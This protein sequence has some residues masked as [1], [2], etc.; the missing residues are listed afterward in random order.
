MKGERLHI[1]KLVQDNLEGFEA[2]FSEAS[3]QAMNQKL[4]LM[5]GSASSGISGGWIAAGVALVAALGSILYILNTSSVNQ[6]SSTFSPSN[7]AEKVV[8]LP[9]K[10]T[11][12]DHRVNLSKESYSYSKAHTPEKD[13]EVFMIE[14]E[15]LSSKVAEG[16]QNQSGLPVENLAS[17]P[18]EGTLESIPQRD[19]LEPMMKE[20]PGTSYNATNTKPNKKELT[21]TLTNEKGCVGDEIEYRINHSGEVTVY[22]DGEKVGHQAKG[23]FILTKNGDI[24]RLRVEES[25]IDGTS[26]NTEKTVKVYALPEW[27][28]VINEPSNAAWPVYQFRLNTPSELPV[29]DVMWSIADLNFKGTQIEHKFRKEGH[30]AISA[31][32]TTQDG[33]T[34][35]TETNLHVEEPFNLLAPNS[36]SPNGDGTN[37][38]FMPY[39]LQVLGLDFQMVIYS[40]SGTPVFTTRDSHD[41][42]D[43]VRQDN[44]LKAQPG[45][46]YVWRVSLKNEKEELEEYLSTVTVKPE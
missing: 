13:S 41:M 25:F 14:P 42:W 31:E 8:T 37:D 1:D 26:R 3:W 32:A 10:D 9:E 5:K 27:N 18:T 11:L 24:H 33:C 28:I 36:F 7:P 45:E 2:P 34:V 6:Q 17:S 38:F 35:R 39:S 15:Q 20:N 4:D 21:L 16:A 46:V 44:G 22:L 12:Q 29:E 43:G 19:D 30:H 23:S 40:Q